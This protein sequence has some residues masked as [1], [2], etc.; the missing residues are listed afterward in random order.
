MVAPA[1]QWAERIM[2]KIKQCV[3]W[4]MSSDVA[5]PPG[6]GGDIG[7][8]IDGINVPSINEVG[9][10]VWFAIDN[11]G[12][13]PIALAFANALSTEGI[14]CE[15]HISEKELKGQKL[16]VYNSRAKATVTISNKGC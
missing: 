2:R 12:G 13:E 8:N 16:L 4:E 14:P 10:K 15:A 3:H 11:P 6:L 1:V 9:V 7:Y 5:S